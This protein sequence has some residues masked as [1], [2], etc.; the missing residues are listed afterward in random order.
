M[1]DGLQVYDNKG[2]RYDLGTLKFITVAKISVFYS[3]IK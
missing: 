3:K 2:Y 1:L